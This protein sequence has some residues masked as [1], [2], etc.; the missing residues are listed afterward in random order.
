MWWGARI[1]AAALVCLWGSCALAQSQEHWLV[2]GAAPSTQRSVA[3]DQVCPHQ[4]VSLT[5]LSDND[6]Q[7]SGD[8]DVWCDLGA[9]LAQK[10]GS[11]VSFTIATKPD[12]RVEQL[13]Q[14]ASPEAHLFQAAL[15][16]LPAGK[17]TGVLLLVDETSTHDVMLWSLIKN[18][19]F[20]TLS[21]LG[22]AAWL[23]SEVPGCGPVTEGFDKML[24]TLTHKYPRSFYAGMRA[25]AED[26]VCSTSPAEIQA[27]TWFS[28]IQGVEVRQQEYERETLISLFK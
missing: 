27:K 1:E 21:V 7:I 5:Y 15:S 6:G 14:Q 24:Q 18:L 20:G 13:G 12:F 25:Q 4:S 3:I 28:A 16:R 17:V 2:L 22:S 19:R 8:P 10:H 9:V 26:Q 23:L 11:L